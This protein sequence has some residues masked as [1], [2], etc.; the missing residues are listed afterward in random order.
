MKK[1]ILTLC[2]IGQI[3]LNANQGDKELI[4]SPEL[5]SKTNE[6][7]QILSKFVD[8]S[9]PV[10]SD[11]RYDNLSKKLANNEINIV[12]F[13]TDEENTIK[14]KVVEEGEEIEGVTY[15]SCIDKSKDMGNKEKLCIGIAEDT[16]LITKFGCE[17]LTKSNRNYIIV[18][19]KD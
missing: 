13:C 1:I 14:F 6:Q 2:I 18:D 17:C 12:E 16:I 19:K 9:R 10:Q 8:Y 4:N 7:M 15:F 11:L 5:D 3:F